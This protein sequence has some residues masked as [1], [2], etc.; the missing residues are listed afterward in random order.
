MASRTLPIHFS[1]ICHLALAI[2]LISCSNGQT[3]SYDEVID[4]E[5]SDNTIPE[6]VS[7]MTVT[8]LTV[9]DSC[10]IGQ[11]D[12][13]IVQDTLVYLFDFKNKASYAFNANSGK[14]L[15]HIQRFGR[16]PEEYLDMKSAAVD[17][18]SIILLDNQ[19]KAIHRYDKFTGRYIR[20]TAIDFIPW[21]LAC[22]DNGSLAFTF[23]PM[24]GGKLNVAQAQ[25]LIYITTPEGVIKSTLLD[26]P[27]DYHEALAKEQYFTTNGEKI[28]FS[29]YGL[30]GFVEFDSCNENASR[31]IHI[32][33]GKDAASPEQ[34]KVY[35]NLRER[36]FMM[37]TPYAFGNHYGMMISSDGTPD[38]Y[39]AVDKVFYANPKEIAPRMLM[40]PVAA[41]KQYLYAIIDR[42]S[43]DMMSEGG[44]FQTIFPI[45]IDKLDDNEL[46]L[47]RYEFH[48][49][50]AN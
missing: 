42:E 8:T 24:P 25:S 39:L 12:K 38:Y 11:I 32:N 3:I 19:K 6:M 29:S 2:G 15:F 27:A 20:S 7:G 46:L 50:G 23:V 41:Y 43:F 17:A 40:R 10:V 33:F 36:T 28:L 5:K 31:M 30:D 35:E 18:H 45:E 47:V 1:C 9:A 22:F 16:G 34:R 48:T 37:D 26:Y 44:I 21:D 4:F 49:D 13:V 14:Q